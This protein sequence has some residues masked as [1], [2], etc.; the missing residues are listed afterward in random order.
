MTIVKDEHQATEALAIVE[1]YEAFVRYLYPILQTAPRKHGVLR[2]TVLS[3]LFPPI[4]GLYHA[5][6]SRQVSRLHVVDAEFATLRSL[7]RL[8]ARENIRILTPHQHA[9]AL[10]LLSEPGK[11]LGAWQKKLG[12]NAATRHEPSAAMRTEGQAG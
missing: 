5:A 10:A 1:K 7:M 8:L 3:A 2:D 9:T 12:R 11:M 4:G 6:R